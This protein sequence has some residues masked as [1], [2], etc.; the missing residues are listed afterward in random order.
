VTFNTM[1][2]PRRRMAATLTYNHQA[3]EHTEQRKGERKEGREGRER[4]GGV[5]GR[6]AC[7]RTQ[8][9]TVIAASS[10]ATCA[11]RRQITTTRGRRAGDNYLPVAAHDTRHA[12]RFAQNK[13]KAPPS[14]S[15]A[16]WRQR[17]ANASREWWLALSLPSRTHCLLARKHAAHRC[18]DA[19]RCAFLR[20][21]TRTRARAP[22]RTRTARTC[23]RSGILVADH[24][25][26]ISGRQAR[27]AEA[28]AYRVGAGSVMLQA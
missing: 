12:F 18:R 3:Y 28:V 10:R 22:A 6:N 27:Q 19:Y 14:T 11:W 23:W 8:Y 4:I 16:P 26:G 21:R 20:A 25:E 17:A 5:G 9:K 15:S 13:W 7:Y 1:L 24:T 2:G